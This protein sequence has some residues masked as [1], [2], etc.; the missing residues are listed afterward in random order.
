MNDKNAVYIR[1]V[2]QQCE[3]NDPKKRIPF[4]YKD[5]N[6]ETADT[7]IANYYNYYTNQ[8]SKEINIPD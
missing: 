5:E 7:W 1:A 6:G 3:W 8:L 4:D 2:N